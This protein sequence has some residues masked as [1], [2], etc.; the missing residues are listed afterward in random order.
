[1]ALDAVIDKLTSENT[2]SG[3]QVSEV[4]AAHG[5]AADLRRRDAERCDFM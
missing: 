1:M 2:L 3:E 4:V 5:N